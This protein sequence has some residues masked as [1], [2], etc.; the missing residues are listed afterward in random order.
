MSNSAKFLVLAL[1]AM[2]AKKFEEAGSLF[3]QASE[4]A[5]ADK[6]QQELLKYANV[7]VAESAYESDTDTSDVDDD[8][9]RQAST[10]NARRRSVSSL[11]RVKQML[12]ASMEA[13]ASEDEFGDVAGAVSD[14]DDDPETNPDAVPEFDPDVPGAKLLPASFSQD[15]VG[16]VSPVRVKIR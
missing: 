6:L 10:S 15:N 11:K 8:D 5:D 1:Q 12:A 3:A 13:T 14:F 9:A 4:C 7:Q 2:G 16:T